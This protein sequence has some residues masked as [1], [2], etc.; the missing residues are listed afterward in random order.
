MSNDTMIQTQIRVGICTDVSAGVRLFPA[1][2]IK[3]HLLPLLFELFA[4]LAR[5]G[6]PLKH[7]KDSRIEY[8]L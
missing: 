1:W 6:F 8:A 2:T 3:A 5:L 4:K 7:L